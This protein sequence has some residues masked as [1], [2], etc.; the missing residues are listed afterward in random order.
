MNVRSALILILA[1]AI[2]VSLAA[3]AGAF[4]GA[5]INLNK[6]I[7]KTINVKLSP[8]LVQAAG[9]GEGLAAM[10]LGVTYGVGYDLSTLAGYPF[11][12]G[13]IGALTEGNVNWGLGLSL[14]ETHGVAFNGAS[15]GVPL[16]QQSLTHTTFNNAIGVNNNFASEQAVLPFFGFPAI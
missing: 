4:I 7:G 6:Q 5:N 3:P 12:Y 8:T 15:A 1:V 16:A 14:D 2:V 11:G 9:L 13:G 10:D